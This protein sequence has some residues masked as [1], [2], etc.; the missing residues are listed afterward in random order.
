MQPRNLLI[1]AVV[2]GVLLAL[3]YFAEDRV[4]GT[5]ER[6]AA[7][8][9]LMGA[10]PEEVV[11]LELEWQGSRVRFAR[12]AKSAEAAANAAADSAA[13]DRPWRIVEPFV[14]LADDAAVDRLLAALAGLEAVRELDGVARQDVGLQPPRGSA[15]WTTASGAGKLE[16]GGGVPA[17]RDV[18]VAAS[19]REAPAV[20]SDAFIDELSRPAGEW[21]SR[22]V[23]AATRDRIELVAISP[24]SG[25]A[26]VLVRSGETLR[27]E[28]PVSDLADRD[29]A[30]RLLADLQ[31]LR[32]E[33][34]LD[35]PLAAE[36][37]AALAGGTGGIRT[38]GTIELTIAGESAP[39]RI[40]I[41]TER[42]PGRRIWRAGGQAFE[43]AS[44]LGDVLARPVSEWRSRNW[45]RFENWRIEKVRVEEPVGA[46]ELVRSDGEWLRDGKEIP[47]AAASDLLAALTSATAEQL[48]EPPATAAGGA[49]PPAPV[50]PMAPTAPRLTVTLSDADGNEEVLTLL[51][52]GESGAGLIPARTRGRDVT[53]L[54]SPGWVGEL[55]RKVAA[56]RAAEP[57]ADSA[58]AT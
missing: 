2:V 51:A 5:D 34:F 4:A 22:M 12:A 7:A 42:A 32:I 19:G 55:E 44:T 40:E 54:M 47:F 52:G 8:R 6:A 37:E 29:L 43:S 24:A 9:R 26:V 25:E 48:A 57:V 33:T 35:P 23:V 31:T 3:I 11:A 16:I 1:L 38:P 21:R 28:S 53:L 18:I 58:P 20:T 14:A 50:A 30:D 27:L 13:Q 39:L 45:T 10:T 41:G 17:T 36:A 56:V 15:S 49:S 46:F